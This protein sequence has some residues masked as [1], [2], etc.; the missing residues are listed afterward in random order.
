MKTK[1]FFFIIAF[2]TF[3]NAQMINIPD[4]NF[5]SR[6]LL[7]STTNSV[8][9]NAAGNNIKIDANSDNEI[10]VSEALQ[11]VR[12]QVGSASI[13]SLVGIQ[14]FANLQF[15]SCEY[16]QLTTLDLSN[17]NYLSGLYCQ[18][19]QI[20]SLTLSNLIN[21]HGLYCN[22]NQLTALDLNGLTNL[23]TVNCSNNQIAIL[24]FTGL[25]NLYTLNCQSNQLIDLDFRDS[26]ILQNI[27][28]TNNQL[29][30]L[31]IKNGNI[32][33]NL[34]IGMNPN[35][36]YICAD[37]GQLS[38]VQS[39]ISTNGYANCHVNTYCSFTP[40]GPFYEIQGSNKFDEN[41]NGCDALDAFV[42]N[43]KFNINSGYNGSAFGSFMGGNTGSNNFAIQ[44][45]THII[46]PILENP[47]YFNVFPSSATV[48]FPSSPSPFMQDFCL[49]A[50]GSHPD[51]EILALPFTPIAHAGSDVVYKIIY[52]NNGSITQ[53]GSINLFF[54]D[55]ILDLV[56]SMPT[57]DSQ[58]TNNLNWNFSNLK[59][60]E[61]REIY[62]TL[63]TNSP[64]EVPPLFT[65]SYLNYTAT[66]SSS[67]NDE[68]INDNVFHFRQ[69]IDSHC[70]YNYVKNI[71]GKDITPEEVGKYV[72]YM[73]GIEN[74]GTASVQNIVAKNIIDTS[75]FDIS[76]LQIIETSHSCKTKITSSNKIEFIF[77][78]INLQN[79][80]NANR[81]YVAYKIKTKS[82][83]V[84]GDSFSNL[85]N[86]YFD[87]NFPIE[88]ENTTTNIVNSLGLQ[89]NDIIN[90]IVTYPN[91][92]KDIL[93]FKTEHNITKV[94]VYDIA[95]RI[96]SSNSVSENKID[97]SELKTGNYILKLYTEK[98]II[99]TKII[100]E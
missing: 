12:L 76:T 15:L 22:N 100:K 45:G 25:I 74:I 61:T 34:S 50:N 97:L 79:T 95:G 62:I 31:N 71:K 96:L 41:T 30:S 84:V 21:L 53:S 92:I 44:A 33:A 26:N 86:I 68:N 13:T 87:Y 28:C 81:G 17:L 20:N 70:G 35:I 82:N 94:E 55:S 10:Q 75:K 38:T 51:L 19:N 91:P 89:E 64:I 47:T 60:F 37:E 93:N 3:C 29:E 83:L 5:K 36:K 49:T 48:S 16:N 85:A 57:I 54:D 8:A 52:K 99:N 73:I 18:Y 6:L 58:T 72:Y 23:Q 24:N 32:E 1:I 98:G 56:Q 88:T 2:T 39:L 4:A 69:V 9:Q 63:N 66:I 14:S 90:D 59:P 65:G 78:N 11:V 42:P 46:S 43:L 7:S 27:Y 77:E 80:S 67:A 40:G